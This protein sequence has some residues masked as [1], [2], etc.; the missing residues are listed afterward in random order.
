MRK[1]VLKSFVLA[2]ALVLSLFFMVACKNGES[3]A[4]GKDGKDGRDGLDGKSAYD[5]AVDA[6]FE[7][8]L[9]DWLLSL[10]GPQGEKGETGPQGIQGPKGDTGEQGPQGEQ[11]IQGEKGEQGEQGEKGD[12]G[13]KG[14]KGEQ[15]PKGQTGLTGATGAQGQNGSTPV[16]GEDG[17][18]YVDNVKQDTFWS[19]E[20]K[21][22][23]QLNSMLANVTADSIYDRFLEA[24]ISNAVLLSLS[25]HGYT[26]MYSY[27]YNKFIVLD[28]MGKVAFTFEGTND[29]AVGTD[30]LSSDANCDLYALVDASELSEFYSNYLVSNKN[31]QT[32]L[33]ISTGLD[34]GNQ[35]IATINYVNTSGIAHDVVIRTNGGD[36]SFNGPLDSVHRYGSANV[37]EIIAASSN[38]YFE[39]ATATFIKIKNG[40]IVLTDNATIGGIHAVATQDNGNKYFN[41]IK[42][43]VVGSSEIP[44]ITRD[45]ASIDEKTADGDYSQYVLEVQTIESETSIAQEEDKEYVWANISIAGAEKTVSNV[46]SNA[47]VEEEEKSSHEVKDGATAQTS[48]TSE[49]A[50]AIAASTE[51]NVTAE[52]AII[53]AADVVAPTM[54]EEAYV[55]SI[56]ITG[57]IT[58][59][60]AF[61]ALTPNGAVRLLQDI[62]L[63]GINL[64][65]LG[66]EDYPFTGTIDGN[67]HIIS[68]F[69]SP[70]G[71]LVN[72]AGSGIV[73]KN[74]TL[75]DVDIVGTKVGA[76]IN[77]TTKA[78]PGENATLTLY[79]CNVD[80]GRITSTDKL[81]GL[82]GEAYGTYIS[83]NNRGILNVNVENC[84]VKLETLESSAYRVGG[85]FGYVSNWKGTV[86]NCYVDASPVASGTNG[87]QAKWVGILSSSFGKNVDLNIVNFTYK[88][89]SAAVSSVVPHVTDYKVQLYKRA[90]TNAE[91]HYL[92]TEGLEVKDGENTLF[93]LDG[94]FTMNPTI[95]YKTENGLRTSSTDTELHDV[96]DFFVT[97]SIA[98]NKQVIL[99]DSSNISN[100]YIDTNDNFNATTSPICFYGELDAYDPVGNNGYIWFSKLLKKISPIYTGNKQEKNYVVGNNWIYGG[101]TEE[102][103]Y[104]LST[105]GQ[106]I[107]FRNAW[108]AGIITGTPY[109]KLGS[110]IN[111]EGYNWLDPIGTKAKPFIGMFD[112]CDYSILNLSN[113]GLTTSQEFTSITSQTTGKIFGLFGYLA[114]EGT[115]S[116]LKISVNAVDGENGKTWAA[117]AA[118][119]TGSDYVGETHT[120]F[121]NITILEGSTITATAKVGGVI[122]QAQPYDSGNNTTTFINCIN[123]ANITATDSGNSKAGGISGS[124]G[125]LF[126]N[127]HNYGNISGGGIYVGGICGDLGSGATVTKSGNTNSGVIT[128]INGFTLFFD[129]PNSYGNILA[130]YNNAEG[131]FISSS[132]EYTV[133]NYWYD[134]DKS[135]NAKTYLLQGIAYNKIEEERVPTFNYIIDDVTYIVGDFRDAAIIRS[136]KAVPGTIQL[137]EDITISNDNKIG[138]LGNQSHNIDLNGYTL[139]LGT[140]KY[141]DGSC[142]YATGEINI[143]TN[144]GVL[145]GVIIIIV[146]STNET[147]VLQINGESISYNTLVSETEYTVGGVSFTAIKGNDGN[148]G[149][150]GTYWTL[151]FRSME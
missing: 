26:Y 109:V 77:T 38:S 62:D 93:V 120:T 69:H 45:A 35:T 122:G 108:N 67:G 126:T 89:G 116:N 34:V 54:D 137:T 80:G 4:N 40:R 149:N 138:N 135:G 94:V 25:K 132:E 64:P 50:S 79:N 113:G 128:A 43:A 92:Y 85:L 41:N 59:Q 115:I 124:R 84:T 29:Y 151:D 15:G 6:G 37:V 95:T 130:S 121:S 44:T 134:K 1:I 60:A 23:S 42:I 16:P 9:E 70:N 63:T 71:G 107:S 99:L 86:K 102:N 133:E 111:M 88:E 112:G 81:G 78:A 103:P 98:A 87:V 47:I 90:S 17:H 75:K 19:T 39:H 96:T 142:L 52:V 27:Q 76:F 46:V 21:V 14:P 3:G 129:I 91:L 49:A 8:S 150:G 141:V 68:N 101:E 13:A 36:L 32:V 31:S 55:A 143:S 12:T 114:G 61:E 74:L 24:E 48:G 82:V 131:D 118:T 83:S 20:A 5:L 110:D 136:G 100:Y 147:R 51:D 2:I 105:K 7:G 56:G 104:L 106:L 66:S 10:I 58:L 28:A 97:G 119:N 146:N 73:I 57:Y 140:S 11:G 33:N 139:N 18:W 65:Q 72:Y 127:C 123:Y 125:S 148:A 117:V 53:A 22:I 144:E 30:V 145:R